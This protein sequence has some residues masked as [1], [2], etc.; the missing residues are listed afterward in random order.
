MISE[1][2]EFTSVE[3]VFEKEDKGKSSLRISRYHQ[4]GG[5]TRSL[6]VLRDSKSIITTFHGVDEI[7]DA[8]HKF[9][10]IGAADLDRILIK[11]QNASSVAC[12]KPRKLLEYLEI[13]VGTDKI[14]SA[15]SAC[16]L[17][18]NRISLQRKVILTEKEEVLKKIKKLQPSMD[19]VTTLRAEQSELN[20]CL[21][22]LYVSEQ[23]LLKIEEAL[24]IRKM[25]SISEN[26]FSVLSCVEASKASFESLSLQIRS[27]RIN[28]S[29]KRRGKEM[30]EGLLLASVEQL[31][32]IVL[33]SKRS[34]QIEAARLQKVKGLL[35]LVRPLL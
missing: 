18:G 20:S 14:N 5:Q 12:K 16:F 21:L 34:I 7:A 23:R 32:I 6:A 35:K 13:F 29:K 24:G 2:R 19:T 10:G 27:I 31:E 9:C 25:N 3:A 26:H 28:E 22:K 17:E 1:G 15:A 8:L 30:C 11:Q 4:K 33:E